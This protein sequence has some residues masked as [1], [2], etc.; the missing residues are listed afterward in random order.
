MVVFLFFSLSFPLLPW[1]M[2]TSQIHINLLFLAF[3]IGVIFCCHNLKFR[4][5]P[6]FVLFS[7]YILFFVIFIITVLV[8]DQESLS[9]KNLPNIFRPVFLFLLIFSFYLLM[10]NKSR[11]VVNF[12]NLIKVMSLIV[13]VLLFVEIFYPQVSH[14]LFKSPTKVDIQKTLTSMYGLPYYSAYVNVIF[15]SFALPLF[16]VSKRY[17]YFIISIIFLVVVFLAQ[18]KVGWVVLIL[19]TFILF[20]MF[21]NWSTRVFLFI[22]SLFLTFFFLINIIP[23]IN[24]LNEN[25]SGNAIRT[26]Y[27]MVNDP[28]ESFTLM[29]RIR[30]VEVSFLQIVNG[31][32]LL[33]L[34]VEKDIGMHLE[35]WLASYLYRYGLLGVFA[36]LSFVLV[37]VYMNLKNFLY[38]NGVNNYLAAFSGACFTWALLLPVTQLSSMMMDIAKT[39]IISCFMIALTI[40]LRDFRL[41]EKS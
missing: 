10:N 31:Y 25:M 38:F 20:F 27:V 39:A 29:E 9:V 32:F 7:Y 23:I 21:S 37:M 13:L 41:R 18:S 2:G 3:S 22:L 30:Q 6:V 17:I 14:L 26:L 33:G 15:Y 12:N 28:S 40:K 8:V 19:S 4:A 5:S 1:L 16:L 35:S 11:L 36:W 34:G 24:F